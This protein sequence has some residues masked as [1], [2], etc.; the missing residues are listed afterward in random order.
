MSRLFTF[1]C[2]FTSYFWPTWADIL[3]KEFDYYENWGR[4]GAGNFYIGQSISEASIRR[5]FSSDDTIMVMW[6]NCLREDRYIDNKWKHFTAT[7]FKEYPEIS[8]ERGFVIRDLYYMHMAKN[9]LDHIG[10]KYY[11]MSI[12][13]FSL[14]NGGSIKIKNSK[15]KDVSNLYLDTLNIIK[16]SVHE[17]IFK[18]DWY[19]TGRKDSHPIPLEHLEYIQKILPEFTLKQSTIEWVKQSNDAVLR[20]PHRPNLSYIHDAWLGTDQ[21]LPTDRF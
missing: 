2:S 15:I 16:P 19:N 9:F 13:N 10:C 4:R 5:N 20:A 11:M 21:H 7:I 18:Y 12:M 17:V 8:C 1:G 3:G 14:K 6:S